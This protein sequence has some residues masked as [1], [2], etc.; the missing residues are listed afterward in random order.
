MKGSPGFHRARVRWERVE[1][2]RQ[3]NEEIMSFRD[4]SRKHP[5][6]VNSPDEDK[7]EHSTDKDD[8]AEEDKSDE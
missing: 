2:I 8:S 5:D 1:F 3:S 6:Q 4:W 7:A